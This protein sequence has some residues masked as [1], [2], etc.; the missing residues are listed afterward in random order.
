MTVRELRARLMPRGWSGGGDGLAI[1]PRTQKRF[2]EGV[3]IGL[4]ILPVLILPRR[5]KRGLMHPNR[6]SQI[7][8]L[9]FAVEEL[10]RD[11][12]LPIGIGNCD[13]LGP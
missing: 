1:W 10:S 3:W 9:A 8:G 7:E 11:R 5:T 12:I 13:P 6:V 4:E 2:D